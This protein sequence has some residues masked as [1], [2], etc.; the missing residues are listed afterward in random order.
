[1]HYFVIPGW[2]KA[3]NVGGN[4]KE[5]CSPVVHSNDA[6]IKMIVDSIRLSWVISQE[7]LRFGR[8]YIDLDHR[9]PKSLS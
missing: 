8:C 1:M 9:C 7:P 3:A 5:L 4:E 2:R 6:M